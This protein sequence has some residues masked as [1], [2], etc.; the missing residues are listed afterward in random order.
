[1]TTQD[2]CVTICPYF[3]VPAGNMERFRKYCDKFVE[4]TKTEPG[5]LYYGFSFDGENVHC[6]E[7]YA[8]ADG[9]LAHLGNVGA[10]LE[11]ALKIMELVRLEVHG[12][13]DELAKLKE[14][15][16]AFGPQYYTLEYGFRR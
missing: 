11:E 2:N 15:L 4:M 1:M 13:A 16:G 8:N 3:K 14:P 6:R 10:T 12:P 7:G 9:L 5:C